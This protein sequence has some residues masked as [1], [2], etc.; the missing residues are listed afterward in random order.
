MGYYNYMKLNVESMILKSEA[1]RWYSIDLII[2]WD[3]QWVTM[4][5]D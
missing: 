4:Y 1:N 2:N 3:L 5:V